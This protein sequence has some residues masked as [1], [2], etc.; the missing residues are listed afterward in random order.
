VTSRETDIDVTGVKVEVMSNP[1]VPNIE[2][3]S[4]VESSSRRRDPDGLRLAVSGLSA[5][6]PLLWL[7]W[8]GWYRIH[9]G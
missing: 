7:K 4:E 5:V 6:L 9:Y 8:R 2:Q 1:D 3:L